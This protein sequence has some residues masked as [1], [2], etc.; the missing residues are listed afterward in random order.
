V[1]EVPRVS[2]VSR[3]NSIDSAFR[4]SVQEIRSA[5][6]ANSHKRTKDKGHIGTHKSIIRSRSNTSSISAVTSSLH[7]MSTNV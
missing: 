5:Y 4:T 2:E 6:I 3:E 1:S 7:Y